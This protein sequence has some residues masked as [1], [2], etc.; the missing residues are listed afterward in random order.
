MNDLVSYKEKHNLANGEEGRDGDNHNISDNYGVEGP[1]RKKGVVEIR[2]RQIKN[3][4]ATLLLSQGVPMLVSGDEIRRT[5][6]GNNNAYCQ[7]NDVSWFDWKLVP[8]HEET[9]HFV[10][11]LIAFRKS[12]PTVRRREF[13]SGDHAE[14]RNVPEVSWYGRNGHALDWSQ[15]TL[16]MVAFLAA[17][18]I[19]GNPEPG[20]R[21]MIMMFNSTGDD[22]KYEMPDISKGNDWTLLLDTAAP[23]G[24]DIYPDL[25]GPSPLPSRK[26][27]VPRHS[28]KVYV[29]SER[30]VTS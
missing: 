23:A 21:D 27:P 13:L 9:L 5:Q 30:C 3:M 1:T 7:D 15:S 4:L 11:S 28:L 17:P 16:A 6:K 12:Q 25:D 14:G 29:S 24:E 20:A 8:R 2:R 18:L 22:L 26:V 10:S 19:G